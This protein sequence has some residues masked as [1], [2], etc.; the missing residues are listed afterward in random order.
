MPYLNV[1]EVESALTSLVGP[2]YA[3]FTELITLPHTTWDGRTSHA[4]RIGNGSGPRTG[5]YLIGGL[6]AREWGS[7]DILV[8][9]LEELAK[10]YHT[11]HGITL[12]GKSFSAAAIAAVVDTLDLIV[13]PQVNPDGRHY[14]MTVDS[15]WRKNR[16]PI[17]GGVGCAGVD[18]NRNFDFMWNFPTY[19]SSSA[20]VAS[21]ATT[22]GTCNSPGYSTFI[23]PSAASEPETQNVVSI[24]D[25]RP[26]IRFLIDVHSYG[27]K[28]LYNWG[29]DENQTTTAGMNFRNSGYNGQRGVDGDAYREFIP[30]G[31]L[32]TQI[33]LANR[34]Q[35]A[36]AA[37]RGKS[38]AVESSFDLYPTSGT[39]ID[40]GYGRHFLDGSRSSVY[41]FVIEWGQESSRRTAR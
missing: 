32:N 2:P 30:G 10:A 37:V 31:E 18:I 35:A 13:F 36:I 17:A 16:R 4:V 21:T 25:S 1:V 14:S 8:F 7:S 39:S 24:L 19:Y 27:Q 5:V 12:G 28:I 41:G 3:A 29:D 26:N 15:C 20:P 38:Y 23:G 9:L 33:V 6:H 22:C 40:Y 11:N 34:M